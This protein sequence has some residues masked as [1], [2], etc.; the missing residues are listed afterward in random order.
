MSSLKVDT[1]LLSG[2]RMGKSE[3][4]KAKVMHIFVLAL[5]IEVQCSRTIV[6]RS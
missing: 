1:F 6:S 2:S 3:I 4:V 5:K